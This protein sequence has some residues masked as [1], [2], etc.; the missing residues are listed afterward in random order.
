MR[1]WHFVPLPDWPA[2][3]GEGDTSSCHAGPTAAQ[4]PTLQAGIEYEY[5]GLEAAV[6]KKAKKTKFDD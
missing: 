4:R 3:G 2:Q 1:A 6:P 5:E